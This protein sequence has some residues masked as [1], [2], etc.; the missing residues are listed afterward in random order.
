MVEA[1]ELANETPVR[2]DLLLSLGQ[3]QA[4]P[5]TPVATTSAV[6]EKKTKREAAAEEARGKEKV[7]KTDTAS[8]AMA[9]PTKQQRKQ[10]AVKKKSKSSPL[11]ELIVDVEEEKDDGEEADTLSEISEIQSMSVEDVQQEKGREKAGRVVKAE[12]PSQMGAAVVAVV[13]GEKEKSAHHKQVVSKEKSPGKP[14]LLT[15]EAPS[16]PSKAK[17]EIGR[18]HV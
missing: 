10:Q 15:P 14:A 17:D 2:L 18:A 13:N 1:E 5:A 16:L 12:Q 6:K 4:V 3:G 11:L 7:A 9:P 8:S